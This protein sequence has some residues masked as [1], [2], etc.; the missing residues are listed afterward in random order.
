MT[1]ADL[2][3][4]RP[5]LATVMVG[6]LIVFGVVAYFRIGV[7]LLPDID[8]PVVTITT[9]YPGASPEAVEDR[10]VDKI[11]E[12]VSQINGLKL[13]RSTSMENVGFIVMQ[14]EL[15]VDGDKAA[16]D[17]RDKVSGVLGKLPP[18]LEPP[19]VR[20]FDINAQPVLAVAISGKL[21]VAKLTEIAKDVVKQRL[22]TIRGVGG[23]EIIGGQEKEF[24][25][26][27]DP[28]KVKSFGLSVT[29]VV[30]ALKSQNV[31]IPG[32]R[33]ESGDREF[34]VK[35]KGEVSSVQELSEIIIT[36]MGGAPVKIGDV[37]TVEEGEAERRSTSSINDM[38]AISLLVTKQSG[39]NTVEV[40]NKVKESL[41]QIKT[42]VPKGVK[43]A[44]PTDSSL[45]IKKSITG[46]QEDLLLGGVLAVLII[47]FFLR[48]WRATLISAVALPTSVI[49]TFAFIWAMGFTFNTMTMLALSLSIGMLI[50]DAIVVI[51]NIY[52]HLSSG[53]SPFKAA[54]EATNEIG[55]AVLAT[56][57]S[58]VA[59]FVPVATMKGIIGRF[60]KQFG[61]TVAFAVLVSLFVAFTL[62][63]MLSSRVLRLKENRREFFMFRWM[64]SFLKWL[65]EWYRRLLAISLRHKY[66]T[67]GI[68]VFVF[69]ISLLM[70]MKLSM[71][72]M[73]EEDRGEILVSVE[74]P[75]G[76]S[77]S[78]TEKYMGEVSKRIREIPGVDYTFLTI[79]GER[80]PDVNKAKL[81]VHLVP[82]HR[83]DYS[84]SEAINFIREMFSGE[85]GVK[86]AVE[87]LFSMGGRAGMRSAK[88]QYNIR[89]K[90]YLEVAKSAE[91]LAEELKKTP[92]FVDVDTTYRGGKPETT[93]HIDR[94][95]AAD[96]GVPVALAA[97]SIRT[98]FAGEKAT[99]ILSEG[100]RYDVRVQLDE[101]NRR[102]PEDILRLSVRSTTGALVPLSNFVTVGGGEGPAVIERYDRMRNVTVLANLD[103][104][105]LGEGVKK[106]D[107]LTRK[108]L[109]PHLI[110]KWSGMADIMKDSFQQLF[111]ALILAV[112]MT[113]LI[114]AAQFESFLQPFIIMMS[115][116]LSLIGA[117][118]ALLIAGMPLSIFAMIG[119]IMLMGLVTKNAILL[120]D[121]TNTLRK[122]GM[123]REE[124]LLTAGPVRLRPIL[125]TT[126]AMILGMTPVALAISAG[127][128]M[129]APMAVAVIGGLLTSMFLTLVVVPAL[130]S[131]IDTAAEKV[132][133]KQKSS[134]PSPQIQIET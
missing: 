55:L 93:V 119:I 126:S 66:I 21:S 104:I 5:V 127:G 49:A 25:V 18:D 71:E 98:F 27:V 54:S 37:A 133:R 24:K 80:D 117:V 34:A 132:F 2:S 20:K 83:R 38:S 120:V 17:V 79:G 97:M 46:V 96:L 74:L 101:K 50:D 33:I 87:P 59:V 58:I 112:V 19:V 32:G 111:S 12:E 73:P 63:P 131:I 95:R 122:R 130:Y 48:D 72:M 13:I 52:R 121:Y 108:V 128:E 16:Q 62:T 3:I 89:G 105:S 35:I 9:I 45:F 39:A 116:P 106:V 44:I 29:D 90:D 91:K 42:L 84:Q 61:L 114:L 110:G 124:A 15:E 85:K 88:I 81:E 69:L 65:D 67:V 22:Q 123:G 75:S 40:A 115:L 129:R 47:L 51:E 8:F 26:W 77:L 4:R 107:D 23:I 28:E 7:D 14:F 109:P 82:K 57:M 76:K 31:E 68:G 78:A 118:S 113:Y 99:E 56:T 102:R 53:K 41:E 100:S 6:V 36:Q 64:G 30:S 103:G 43:I 134:V 86:F 70:S 10:V 11:E 1:L 60:F 125:M 94:S 92:G